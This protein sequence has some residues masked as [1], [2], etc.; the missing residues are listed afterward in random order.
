MENVPVTQ[1]Q[2]IKREVST[3]LETAT[4]ME[5]VNTQQA[6]GAVVFVRSLNASVK[7]IKEYFKEI[8]EKAKAAHTVVVKREND[9][10]DFPERAK[11]IVN[12][13][14]T[15]YNQEQERIRLE[16]EAKLRAEAQKKHEAELKKAQGRIDKILTKGTDTQE[17]I[18]LL[19]MELKGDLSDVERQKIESQ[20]EIEIAILENNQE[21]AEAIQQQVTEQAFVAPVV[22]PK[23]EKVSGGV[24][25]KVVEL[26]ITNELA[27]VK[28]IASG[29]L[30]IKCVKVVES[31]IKRFVLMHGGTKAIPGVAFQVKN[32]THVR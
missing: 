8:K 20:L 17:T 11:K 12:D 30:P 29:I 4:A 1:E 7:K 15:E 26:Q 2:E 19:N 13:K 24:T 32:Q 5:I 10:L 25:K 31:E 18:D 21:K 22:L 23:T 6:E 27:I 9:A 3:L 28:A 16:A 14:L